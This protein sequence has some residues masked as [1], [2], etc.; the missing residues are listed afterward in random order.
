MFHVINAK[1]NT[2]LYN[3]NRVKHRHVTI[4]TIPTVKRW[5]NTAPTPLGSQ[6]RVKSR[7]DIME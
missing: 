5:L 1:R 7:I 2:S 6:A 3:I 4:I